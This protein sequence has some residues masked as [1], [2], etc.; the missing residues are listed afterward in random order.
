[1]KLFCLR[2]N[3]NLDIGISRTSLVYIGRPFAASQ[4]S[5]VLYTP[6]QPFNQSTGYKILIPHTRKLHSLTDRSTGHVHERGCVDGLGSVAV[7][8]VISQPREV[9]ETGKTIKR[10]Y[11]YTRVQSG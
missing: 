10:R 8:D 1:M 6:F 5:D 11:K 7:F 3:N 2:V 9:L 4:N